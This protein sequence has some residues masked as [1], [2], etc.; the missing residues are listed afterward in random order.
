MDAIYDVLVVFTGVALYHFNM[1]VI[2]FLVHKI[3]DWKRTIKYILKQRE[4]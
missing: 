3:P 1:E 2:K 4:E